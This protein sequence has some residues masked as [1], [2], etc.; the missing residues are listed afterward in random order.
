MIKKDNDHINEINALQS[1]ISRKFNWD[2]MPSFMLGSQRQTNHA[3][4]KLLT[5]QNLQN[6]LA[7]KS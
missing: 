5:S 6:G 2:N 4:G 3:N 1:L 7:M